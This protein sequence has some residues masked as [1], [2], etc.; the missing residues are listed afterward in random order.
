LGGLG[1]CTVGIIP[2]IN[3][4]NGESQNVGVLTI[5]NFDAKTIYGKFYGALYAFP[6]PKTVGWWI[7]IL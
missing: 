6:N 1:S 5:T 3:G 7:K 2:S 4:M